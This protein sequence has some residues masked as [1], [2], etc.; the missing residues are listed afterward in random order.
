MIIMPSTMRTVK[1]FEVAGKRILV[2]CDIDVHIAEDG[3]IRDDFRIKRALPTIEYLREEGAKIILIG[4]MG[5]PD[6]MAVPGLKLDPIRRTLEEYLE[7]PVAKTEDCVGE[8]VR[9]AVDTLLPGGV[10][11]LENVR[12]HKGEMDDN[13]VFAK[14][15]AMLG[16]FYINDAFA[17]SH[18]KH[19]S[20]YAICRYLPSAAGLNLAKE[21][22]VLTGLMT[23]PAQPFIVIIGGAK[24]D[25]S[26][27]K[28]V[29]KFAASADAV[30]I[31]GLI[32]K[33]IIEKQLE[34]SHAER[35]FFPT[36]DLEAPDISDA[37]IGMFCKKILE[38]KTVLWN[39]PFGKFED[40]QYKKGTLAIAKA[41]IE[42]KAFSVAG[43]GETVEFLVQESLL[44]EFS[45][46]STG[47]GA[48]LQFLSGEAMPVLTA[49][50]AVTI[51]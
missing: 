12:F 37:T 6:G 20:M 14:Q 19:A 7:M 13:D 49:L 42:S 34:I 1:D 25:A 41:I 16:E 48:M 43:G 29:E 30:L 9:K 38:A 26:K 46:V 11:L 45:H 22:E 33:G 24:A 36:G 8:E 3:M 4:H 2:R 15:L 51:Y 18:R 39:G 32:R 10:L 5:R 40:A 21:V 35:I 27:L 50:S 44:A 28:L 17:N 47:G 31:S 23:H